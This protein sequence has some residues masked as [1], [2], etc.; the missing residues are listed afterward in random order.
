MCFFRKKNKQPKVIGNKFN[1]GERINFKYR[2]DMCPGLIYEVKY[3][4]DNQILYD[5]QIGGECPAIIVNIKEEE[6]FYNISSRK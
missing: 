1:I 3:G 5:V 4:K 6:I 2:G